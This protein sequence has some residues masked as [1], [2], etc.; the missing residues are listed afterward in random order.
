MS[1]VEMHPLHG[2]V[3]PFFALIIISKRGG[4]TQGAEPLSSPSALMTNRCR[5]QESISEHVRR[6]NNNI[7]SVLPAVCSGMSLVSWLYNFILFYFNL[8]FSIFYFI[9]FY[10]SCLHFILFILLFYFITFFLY[11]IIMLFYFI[12]FYF[13]ILFYYIFSILFYFILSVLSAFYLIYF[14]ILFY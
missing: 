6:Q 9:L 8:I 5:H 11:F 7:F 1:C 14:I 10:L 12:L 13:I 4:M 2:S 3:A